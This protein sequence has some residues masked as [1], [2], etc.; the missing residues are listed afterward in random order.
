MARDSSSVQNW[1]TDVFLDYTRLSVGFETGRSEM[2]YRLPSWLFMVRIGDHV[3]SCLDLVKRLRN[4]KCHICNHSD[5]CIYGHGMVSINGAQEYGLLPAWTIHRPGG[6]L[7][8]SGLSVPHHIQIMSVVLCSKESPY[9]TTR[10]LCLPDNALPF[11]PL[12]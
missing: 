10:A 12:V 3:T 2:D 11:K 7:K 1:M 4:G 8:A 5:I 9:Q 6:H